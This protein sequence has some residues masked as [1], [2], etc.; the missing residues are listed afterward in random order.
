MRAFDFVILLFSFVYAAAITHV[1]AAAGDIIMA[2]KRIKLS[3]LNAGWMLVALLSTGAWWIGLWD[4]RG[5]KAWDMPTVGF[6]FATSSGFYLYT[7]LVSPRIPQ[8]GEV[9]LRAFHRQEGRK[10]L[11]WFAVLATI[12]VGANIVFARTN[13]ATEFLIQNSTV[14][15]MA[16]AAGV[17]AVFVQHR[18]VQVGCLA[19]E[20]TAWVIYYG[21][22]Q[23]ALS[24]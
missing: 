20:L 8:T 23:N 19:V 7:R 12:T 6:L 9:D 15:P 24:G 18:W 11:I 22:Q 2:A 21:F 14:I 4:M 16:I 13:G 10:Y 17:A 3:A 5:T 1:L